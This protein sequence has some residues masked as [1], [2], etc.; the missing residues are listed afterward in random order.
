MILFSQKTL[1]VIWRMEC[2]GGSCALG[3]LGRR[4]ILG[5]SKDL[6]DSKDLRSRDTF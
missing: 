2:S 5:H 6:G 1:S 3:W 4:L